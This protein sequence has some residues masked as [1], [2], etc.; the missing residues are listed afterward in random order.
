MTY[1][2]FYWPGLPGR[3]EFVRLVLEAAGA[4]YREMNRVPAEAGGGMAAMSAYLDGEQGPQIPF[5]PPF[6]RDGN[7]VLAQTPVIVAHL[8]ET[9]G[10]APEAPGDR[11]F[12]RQIATTTADLVAE[13][14]DVHHPVG[15]GL[16]YEDQKPEA[17]RRASEFRESRMPKF[18]G[19]YD[20]I[21]KANPAGST[22]LVGDRMSYADLGLFQVWQGLRY[23][24]PRRMAVLAPDFVA[25]SDLAERVA[26]QPRLAAYLASA[27]RQPFNEDGIFRH[28]PELDGE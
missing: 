7:L 11:L 9:L 22:W 26:G 16:Y 2:L 3:G 23:A 17:A 6:L 24:F 28:Y 19:W 25:I 1:D 12:A 4:D 20:A 18:L 27:R 21:L 14:H 15:V 10:L 5:A 8:G 13:A